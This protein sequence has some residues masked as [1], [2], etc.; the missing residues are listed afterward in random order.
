M[1]AWVWSHADI[2]QQHRSTQQSVHLL[3]LTRLSCSVEV[4]SQHIEVLNPMA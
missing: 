3:T 1:H 4:Q 2:W